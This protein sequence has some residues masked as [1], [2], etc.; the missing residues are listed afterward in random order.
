[1][2]LFN[3]GAGSGGGGSGDGSYNVGSYGG[4]STPAA[5][6]TTI[7]AAI[8]A[9]SAAGGGVVNVPPGSYQVSGSI[10]PKSNVR[11]RGA[12]D[13][14]VISTTV[15]GHIIASGSGTLSNFAVEDMKFLGPV[16]QTVTVP[17]RARTTSGNGADVAI[18]VDGDLDTATPGAGTIT[19]IAV[20][21]ITVEATTWLP[22]RLF[23][24]RGKVVVTDSLF[25]NC[26]D[27]GFGFNQEVVCA[28]NTS[29][30]SADNGFS[31]SRA[32]VKV[33]CTGNTVENAAYHGLWLSGFTG[34]VGPEDF[35][36]TG[37]TV[38]GC[39]LSGVALMDAPTYGT[40][41]GNT[42]D[43]GGYRGNV[44][45]PDDTTT[46]GI[47][48]KGQS[49]NPN[50]PSTFSKG[51]LIGA[52][53][54]RN[55]PRAGIYM[56]GCTGV[57][58]TENQII[59]C[60]SQY[61]A[62]GVST[63][64]SSF[65]SQNVGIL[66]DVPSTVTNCSITGND[67]IDTRNTPYCNWALFPTAVAAVS[68]TGN[69]MVGC[70]NASNLPAIVRSDTIGLR[71]AA[72]EVMPRWAA[73]NFTGITMVS[74]AVRFAYFTASRSRVITQLTVTTG[75]TAAGATPSLIRYGLYSVASSGDLTQVGVTPND[76][77]LLAGAINLFA[78]TMSASV[79]LIE[80]QLYAIAALVVT[81]ATAPT[82]AGALPSSGNDLAQ[83]PRMSA[84]LTAQSDLNSTYT[85]GSLSS[86]Q[87]LIYAAALQ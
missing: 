38:R 36:V 34:S 37:N 22:I 78:Q 86:T 18:W 5:T 72:E 62:D 82:L 73:Q 48:I 40:F 39:G 79:T 50:T 16:N 67:V 35:T 83:T 71:A 47:F 57:K 42:I 13:A 33:T 55:A 6:L 58:V 85:A 28:N 65:T 69:R 75:T 29:I 77:S 44:E 27:V 25:Y 31:I 70:R 20:H 60:G 32:N 7:Q 45:A 14:T 19:N 68:I 59:D 10:T 26:M 30:M 81:A 41:V 23:G 15:N 24:I 66:I 12:G 56:N 8:D 53:T 4:F 74:G 43:K 1:M 52:N 76:T 46:C 51:L 17:T 3:G 2:P 63:I 11:F 87:S 84:V 80:G 54:I 64:S 61:F 49:T 9:C 21:R